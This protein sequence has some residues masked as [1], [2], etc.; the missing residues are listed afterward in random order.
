MKMFQADDM[1]IAQSL[2]K[3]LIYFDIFSHP[4]KSDEIINYCAYPNLAMKDGIR[5]L[6]KLKSQ[7]LLNYQ[8]GFYFLGK[9]SSKVAKRLE[10][11]RLADKRLKTAYKYGKLIANF[12]FVRAVLISGSLSK[13]VMKPESD[14]DFFIITKPGKLWACRAFLTFFK[15]IFL[16]DSYRNFC[17]NY[18]I[19]TESLEITDK[20]IFTATEIAFILPVYNYTIY[21]EFMASNKWYRAAFP[22]I[23][24]RAELIHITPLFIKKLLENLLNYHLRSTLPSSLWFLNQVRYKIPISWLKLLNLVFLV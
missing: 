18:F 24:E 21:Q 11:N 9:D 23:K 12:P 5:I 16:G 3:K 6:N 4:L 22:N 14:I 13:H 15:K 8:D 7:N 17:L 19:D 10:E 1:A 20:N 2:I